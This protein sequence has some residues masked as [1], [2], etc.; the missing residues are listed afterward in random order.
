[1]HSRKQKDEKIPILSRIEIINIKKPV[2][3]RIG[4]SKPFIGLFVNNVKCKESA[5]E[6]SDR[7]NTVMVFNGVCQ[8]FH[9]IIRCIK[10]RKKGN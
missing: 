4:I 1:M 7:R 10:M 9:H 3:Q 8:V 6:S 5:G 2:Y